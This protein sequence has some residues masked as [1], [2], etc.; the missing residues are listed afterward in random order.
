MM[1]ATGAKMEPAWIKEGHPPKNSRLVVS[2]SG[3]KDSVAVCLHLRDLGYSSSDF[4]RVFLDTGWEDAAS[5]EYL[6]FLES[7]IGKIDRI[8]WSVK[9]SPER[10]EI[11]EKYEK[12]LGHRSAMIREILKHLTFSSGKVRWC[13]R[14]LKMEPIKSYLTDCE[15]E[16]IN[17][18]GIR[19]QESLTRS[20]MTE[21]EWNDALDCWTWRPIINWSLD[22]V[23][24]QHQRHG[25]KPHPHYFQG[26]S[27]VG[28]H[29]C[30][31]ARKKEIA[32]LAKSDPERIELIRNIEQ[33]VSQL[34]GKER[35]FFKA[36]DKSGSWNIDRV[37]SWSQTT[38]GGRQFELFSPPERDSG[39]VR[40]GMC[41]LGSGKK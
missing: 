19:S 15:V 11:A 12:R 8:N 17:V 25:L 34:A 33:D 1:L 29:P 21:H 38:R 40:W 30:I 9:L 39:C 32:N 13:T 36:R 7:K 10:E 18:V 27:R 3:G 41:D 16:P 22:D 37:V 31:F 2:V 5:Y 26:Y 23:I 35:T 20:Q 6:D 24:A 28:C 4:D 14:K